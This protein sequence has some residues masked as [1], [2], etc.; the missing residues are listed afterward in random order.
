MERSSSVPGAA[1]PA[2]VERGVGSKRRESSHWI[3]S[4]QWEV[5]FGQVV[6]G[7]D[8]HECGRREGE[9]T[10]R[11]DEKTERK[12]DAPRGGAEWEDGPPRGKDGRNF[13]T[14]GGR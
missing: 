2:G 1:V 3:D 6:D 8:T 5:W 9:K 12:P 4:E 11:G 7:Q 13:L 14:D 10:E